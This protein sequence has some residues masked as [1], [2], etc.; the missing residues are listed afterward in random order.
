MVD[1]GHEIGHHGWVHENPADFDLQGERDNFERGLEAL[2]R[3]AG[4]RPVGYR[5]PA[6]DFSVNTIDILLEYGMVYDGSHS[7]TDH[8]AYYLRKGDQWSTTEPYVFGTPTEVVAIPFYWSLD[9]FVHFEFVPPLLTHQA[10]PSFVREIWQEEFDYA[11]AECN[12][13]VYEL[14]MH[15]QVIGRG[16]RLRMLEGLIQYMKSQEGVVF[17]RMID[18][19]EGWKQV[20]PLHSWT[21]DNAWR[22]GGE[23]AS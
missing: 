19:A 4:V 22:L 13:G 23:G 12:G 10:P 7:A 8:T 2:D 5:S 14:C 6:C 17:R 16:P 15:P 20:N 3:V 11:L 1:A 18:Y 21:K 9:D